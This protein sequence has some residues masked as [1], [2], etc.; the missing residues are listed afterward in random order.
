MDPAE[1][2]GGD[3]S[4]DEEAQAGT[5]LDQKRSEKQDED[6][7]EHAAFGEIECVEGEGEEQGAHGVSQ[8]KT[9]RC[10]AAQVGEQQKSKGEGEE[11]V[12]VAFLDQ[13]V[14]D[15]GEK[16]DDGEGSEKEKRGDESS[17][18]RRRGARARRC[19]WQARWAGA[20]AG[21]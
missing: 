14:G 2:C 4:E 20:E 18:R 5:P 8:E 21:S 10:R 12:G 16:G 9:R 19:R 6:G 7:G 3:Q 17:R 11:A 13:H 15:V 1:G